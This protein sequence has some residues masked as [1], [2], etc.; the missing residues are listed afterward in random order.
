MNTFPTIYVVIPDLVLSIC[1]AAPLLIFWFIG[2]KK[3]FSS[4][5][6]IKRY[7]Y[8]L[9]I[10]GIA[11][12]SFCF[13]GN[14]MI[15]TDWAEMDQLKLHQQEIL[16]RICASTYP[17]TTYAIFLTI[18]WRFW[19]IFFD[20][21]YSSSQKNSEWKYHLDPSLVEHNFWLTH[22]KDYGSVYWTKNIVIPSYFIIVFINITLYHFVINTPY[23]VY[24]GH[25]WAVTCHG[26]LGV[27][28]LTI[29]WKVPEYSDHFFIKYEMK[30]LSTTMLCTCIVAFFS[31]GL[32]S[33]LSQAF[34]MVWCASVGSIGFFVMAYE[35]NNKT[36]KYFVKEIGVINDNSIGFKV[37]IKKGDKSGATEIQLDE[38]RDEYYLGLYENKEAKHPLTNT[39]VIHLVTVKD[40]T[41]VP[42]EN[43]DYRPKC[44][45]L[46]TVRKTNDYKNKTVSLYWDIPWCCFGEISYKI[47]R[48]DRK[49]EEVISIL[50][51]SIPFP[52]VII[53]F[54]VITIA[55]I[56]DNV[57]ES[58]PSH[59]IIVNVADED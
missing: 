59:T 7:P 41:Y 53:S 30:L 17:F 36:K 32:L 31:L 12:I 24:I 26:L 54:E 16:S 14:P 23:W 45:S 49:E 3:M 22:K 56:D 39:N 6:I 42:P 15:T 52:D 37:R 19:H 10:Q 25:G 48:D 57:Y 47:T 43:M 5:M 35:V 28:A 33:F 21:K 13:V 29:W 44:I 4:V 9:T 2:F 46:S 27:F 55:T 8:I 58:G 20:L 40:E 34:V 11:F 38:E 51:Y 18:A 1:V 50:P